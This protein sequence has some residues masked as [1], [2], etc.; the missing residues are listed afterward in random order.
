M[1]KYAIRVTIS[2]REHNDDREHYRHLILDGSREVWHEHED[3][4]MTPV[5]FAALDLDDQNLI[6]EAELGE[7]W[8]DLWL[9]PTWCEGAD[10]DS[11]ATFTT[12]EDA[13]SAA[14]KLRDESDSTYEVVEVTA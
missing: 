6:A 5:E 12:R 14:G 9:Y 13:E 4:P 10:P 3:R 8:G 11:R 7:G 2:E 1:T